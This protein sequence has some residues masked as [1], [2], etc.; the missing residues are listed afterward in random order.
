MSRALIVA[1]RIGLVLSGCLFFG[2]GFAE[3]VT[4]EFMH[5]EQVVR[6]PR[7]VE[8][9]VG[10]GFVAFGS[11][12]A[13]PPRWYFAEPPLYWLLLVASTALC[14]YS[15]AV[16]IERGSGVL[17]VALIFAPA[18][19]AVALVRAEARR[20]DVVQQPTSASKRGD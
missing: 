2:M 6:S 10:F 11:F 16:A 13:I 12:L 1:I 7:L 9:A 3:L 17:N 8:V 15:I 19:V 5:S 20:R 18:A 14:I 4:P